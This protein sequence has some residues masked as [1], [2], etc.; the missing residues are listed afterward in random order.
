MY[1]LFIDRVQTI[2]FH[3]EAWRAQ[4]AGF[5]GARDS[6]LVSNAADPPSNA[7]DTLLEGSS[8]A[9]VNTRP[10]IDPTINPTSPVDSQELIAFKTDMSETLAFSRSA[11][12]G[13]FGP[14]AADR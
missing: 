3:Y 9:T 6:R 4:C 8:M 13:P 14:G 7:L 12:Y 10:S 5:K 11:G 2:P 1:E